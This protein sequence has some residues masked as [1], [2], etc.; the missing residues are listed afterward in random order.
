MPMTCNNVYSVD[1]VVRPMMYGVVLYITWIENARDGRSD[2][3]F[4]LTL[5]MEFETEEAAARELNKWI[6]GMNHRWY[7]GTVRGVVKRL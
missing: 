7:G 6:R 3:E 4:K 1:E 5:P 2:R